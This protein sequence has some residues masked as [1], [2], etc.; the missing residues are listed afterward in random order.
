MG[1]RGY[2]WVSKYPWITRIEIPAR[3]WGRV[4]IPYLSNRAETDIIL[5]VPADTH[6]HYNHFGNF[7]ANA[8]YKL[9]VHR[10]K[11][12]FLKCKT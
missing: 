1:I 4:Q 5:P 11:Q 10:D 3:I 6:R 12:F 7:H 2:A 9:N 8:F